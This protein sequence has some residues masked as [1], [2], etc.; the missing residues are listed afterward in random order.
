MLW[1]LV[2]CCF[3]DPAVEKITHTGIYIGEGEFIHATTH[4]KPVIQVSRI[5]DP[6]WTKVFVSARRN[7]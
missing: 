2:I 7:K 6:H 5:S 4:E 3:S 1:N